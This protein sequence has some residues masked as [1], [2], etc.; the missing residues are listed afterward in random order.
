MRGVPGWSDGRPPSVVIT[1]IG[2]SARPRLTVE[3][4]QKRSETRSSAPEV[5][6][7]G[8]QVS[9]FDS[10][11]T[12]YGQFTGKSDPPPTTAN[13]VV[14]HGADIVYRVYADLGMR[15]A[16]V[17]RLIRGDAVC[18]ALMGEVAWVGASPHHWL[19]KSVQPYLRSVGYPW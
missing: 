13:P 17:K 14:G 11:H 7:P 16:E 2:C 18:Y 6:P 4:S 15:V 12:D 8:W 9:E 3:S 19:E 10:S 5:N 1:S